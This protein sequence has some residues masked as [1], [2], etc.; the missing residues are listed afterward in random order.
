MFIGHF[1]LGYPGSIKLGLGLW[2]SV[3]ATLFVELV[4]FASGVWMYASVTRA[5][6]IGRWAFIGFIG[7]LLVSYF[8]GMGSPPPSVTALVAT[9]IVGFAVITLWARWFDRHRTPMT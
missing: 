5:R 4:M 1:A 2:N 8:A 3:P 9:T 6:D 7:L